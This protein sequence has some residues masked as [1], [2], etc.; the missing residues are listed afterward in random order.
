M[1]TVNQQAEVLLDDN[2]PVRLIGTVLDITQ[3]SA[4]KIAARHFPSWV[5]V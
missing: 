2:V 3:R 5:N 4:Q 1:K